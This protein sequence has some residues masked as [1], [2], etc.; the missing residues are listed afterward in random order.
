MRYFEHSIYVGHNN[1]LQAM[2]PRQMDRA[3]PSMPTP[4]RTRHESPLRSR[5]RHSHR[6][7]QHPAVLASVTICGDIHRQ[8]WDL[9]EL[10]RNAEWCLIRPTSLCHVC[11]AFGRR[12]W[13]THR[14]G[15]RYGCRVSL[16]TAGTT[17]SKRSLCCWP[18]KHGIRTR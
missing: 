13:G 7:I 11:V 10:L 6:R 9:L 14:R 12:L 4:P 15:G 18:S 8:F 2:R 3:T 5:A 16:S 17:V 1:I